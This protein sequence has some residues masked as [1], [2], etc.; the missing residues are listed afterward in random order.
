MAGHDF[1][2]QVAFDTTRDALVAF[3]SRTRQMDVSTIIFGPV[4]ATALFVPLLYV[5]FYIVV[6]IYR[7]YFH[8]L[9]RFP[10]P[11][12]AAISN[13]WLLEMSNA[14][15]LEVVLERLHDEYGISNLTLRD[16][17]KLREITR[18]GVKAVR[19]GPN[20]L[21][22]TDTSLYKTIYSQTKPWPKDADFY[23]G[24]GT[25][26][27]LFVEHD[28]A[29]HKERRRL[30]NSFFSKSTIQSL[31]P[32]IVDK[33]KI[34]M[35]RID[36]LDS[37]KPVNIGNAARCLN[38]D[39]I[40]EYAFAKSLDTLKVSNDC[41]EADFLTAFDASGRS[42][43][44]MIYSPVLRRVAQAMPRGI[45][46]RLSPEITKLLEFFDWSKLCVQA[47]RSREK[48]DNGKPVMF[49]ALTSLDVVNTAAEGVDILAA[50][51]DT[52]AFSL[53]VGLYYILR[54]QAIY[55]KLMDA[56]LAAIPDQRQMP[57]L[58]N[59]EKIEYLSA[60]VKESVRVASAV[61]GRLPRVVPQDVQNLAV[62]GKRVPPGT[63]VGISAYTMHNSTELWG[64]D[65]R[66]FHPERW[67]GEGGKK[68]DQYMVAFSKGAR[69]C[70]GQNLAFA[71]LTLA[72]PY[73]LRNYE[74]NLLP[75]ST[76]AAND[77]F[78]KAARHPGVL[79]YM[80]R[81]SF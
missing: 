31:E 58:P 51:T 42:L 12:K 60:C 79:V 72:L 59:L 44:T 26:H 57:T 34:L 65:A 16:F 49:D 67:L 9:S 63:T 13:A 64:H 23:S 71:E 43:W 48:A 39:F 81:R 77:Y 47:Y 45:T 6:S 20:E 36:R 11:K 78:T 61:P 75:D 80:S 7:I 8:P 19:I 25:P 54:D 35:A 10:G 14:G 15:E 41:F 17:R 38:A 37:S 69:S 56:L 4:V 73:L 33:V 24:F 2:L 3:I 5:A 76:I 30:L 46:K 21:H 53:C 52:T 1:S 29:L 66:S 50:G 40:S 22:L 28:V 55:R 32:M 27:T 18:L 62:D 74:I 70:I 68:L